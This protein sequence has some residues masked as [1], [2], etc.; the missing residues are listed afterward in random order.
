MSANELR[1]SFLS[2][3]NVL[4]RLS[5]CLISYPIARI[6]DQMGLAN[7]YLILWGLL[8]LVLIM[9]IYLAKYKIHKACYVP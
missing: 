5:F 7:A 4:T 2:F 9:G 3:D 6:I 8:M 1:T